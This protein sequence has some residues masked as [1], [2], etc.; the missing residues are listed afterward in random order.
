M[1]NGRRNWYPLADFAVPIA[2]WKLDSFRLGDN[3]TFDLSTG[4]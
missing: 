3:R 4:I 2:P 1:R